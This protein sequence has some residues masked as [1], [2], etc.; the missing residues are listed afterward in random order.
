MRRVLVNRLVG[1]YEPVRWLIPDDLFSFEHYKRTV[2]NKI[3]WRSSP[4][5][6]YLLEASTN[7]Q[8]F[9]V[10]L[11]GEPSEQALNRFWLLVDKRIRELDC[12]PIRLFIKPEPHKRK[13]LDNGA[14]RLISSVS[15]IDQ[16]IDQMCFSEMNDKMVENYHVI[17]SKVGWAPYCK[18]YTMVPKHWVSIDKSAWD[19]SMQPWLFEIILEARKELCGNPDHCLFNEWNRVAAAR[20]KLLFGN[21]VFVTSGGVLLRQL[22]PGV[23][24]SGCVNTI[25]DNSFAQDILHDRVCIETQQIATEQWTCGDDTYLQV[26]EKLEEYILAMGQFSHVKEFAKTGEFCG[27]IYKTQRVQPSYMGKHIFNMLHADPEFQQDL[28]DSYYL[29]YHKSDIPRLVELGLSLI[30]I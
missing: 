18:G 5:Y 15:V 9:E 25:Y 6:P 10:G 30:H 24:K 12:D 8:L 28:V 22:N 13:K 21:P 3:H 17:P 20:Y 29:M 16:I 23:Q 26:P 1:K 19:W 14:Y 7:G 27:N 4:G 2:K 11:D